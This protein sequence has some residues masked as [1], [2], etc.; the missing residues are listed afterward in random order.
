[1]IDGYSIGKTSGPS[2]WWHAST[3]N[4]DGLTQFVAADSSRSGKQKRLA[5]TAT[6][7]CVIPYGTRH[8]RPRS[9]EMDFHQELNTAFLTVAINPPNRLPLPPLVCAPAATLRVL[10]SAKPSFHPHA[11]PRNATRRTRS[12]ITA[13]DCCLRRRVRTKQNRDLLST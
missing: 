6:V 1:M 12:S 11:T 8:P 9:S 4:T 10:H 5:L 2:S 3:S 13:A 7:G